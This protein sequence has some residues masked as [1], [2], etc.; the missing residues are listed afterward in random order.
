MSLKSYFEEYYKDRHDVTSSTIFPPLLKAY[1]QEFT[2]RTVALESLHFMQ[3][4]IQKL[5]KLAKVFTISDLSPHFTP[6][7]PR[8]RKR[9]GTHQH[10][11]DRIR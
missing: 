3:I 5:V 7:D 11:V 2:E 9:S 1:F 4:N 10:A 8:E 6:I